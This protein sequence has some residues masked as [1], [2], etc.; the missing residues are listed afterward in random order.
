MPL[1][2]EEIAEEI[3]NCW[4]EGAAVAHIHCR[5]DQG[6]AAMEFEKFEKTASLIR[7]RKDCDIIL[8]ITTSGG[9]NLKEED[10]LRPFTN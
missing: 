7:A 8:N 6:R 4:K 10:R 1:E 9:V 3:Y 5:D 2:P